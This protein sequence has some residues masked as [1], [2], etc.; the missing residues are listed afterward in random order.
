MNSATIFVPFLAFLALSDGMPKRNREGEPEGENRPI[1]RKIVI[2]ETFA[3]NISKEDFREMIPELTAEDQ[4]KP[5]NKLR[6][7][8]LPA[9]PPAPIHF[10][11]LNL[12]N[13]PG[14][15]MP[16]N[17]KQFAS[18]LS[19]N[20]QMMMIPVYPSQNTQQK[21][22]PNSIQMPTNSVA[23]SSHQSKPQLNLNPSEKEEKWETKK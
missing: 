13:L 23:S 6:G 8:E 11:R 15:Q 18:E 9:Q 3:Y 14:Q 10:P 5:S 17:L 16:S 4:F 2:K 20:E 12:P 22:M 1:G 7:K 19:A 21:N